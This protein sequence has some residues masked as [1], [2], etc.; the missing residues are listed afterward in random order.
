[1]TTTPYS[2]GRGEADRDA[3]EDGEGACFEGEGLDEEGGLEPFAVDAGESEGDESDRLGRWRGRGPCRQGSISSCGAGLAGSPASRRGDRTSS[4]P[5]G[6]SRSRGGKR[7]PRPVRRSGRAIAVG[8][9]RS[10][11][12]PRLRATRARLRREVAA[13]EVAV[14]ADHAGHQG[15]QDE[16]G[17][18]TFAEGDDGGVRDHRWSRCTFSDRLCRLFEG[19]VEGGEGG[20]SVGGGAAA[21][22]PAAP[23][24]RGRRR[25]TRTAP[26]P[27]GR[28]TARGRASV[29]PDRAR[30]SR[31]PRGGLIRHGDSRRQQRRHRPF[32]EGSR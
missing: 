6:G 12:S 23:V 14:G 19:D 27:A 9:A 2:E 21:R 20:G 13:A 17:F 31:T 8:S 32:G 22:E 16:D 28:A 1:M 15:G 29:A 5:G 26:L 18:E 30:R 7:G 11:R 4:G 3:L 25:R 24:R 10:P